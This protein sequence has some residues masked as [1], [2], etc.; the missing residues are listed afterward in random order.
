[1]ATPAIC[2]VVLIPRVLLESLLSPFPTAEVVAAEEG[3]TVGETKPSPTRSV[4]AAVR[5]VC[6]P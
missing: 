1:M 4:V 6:C 3:E 5:E 2:P